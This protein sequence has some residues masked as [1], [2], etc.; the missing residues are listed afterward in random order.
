[1][2]ES[3]RTDCGSIDGVAVAGRASSIVVS[4]A[5]SPMK[6]APGGCVLLISEFASKDASEMVTS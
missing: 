4:K 2:R 6:K 3:G 1:M 5:V